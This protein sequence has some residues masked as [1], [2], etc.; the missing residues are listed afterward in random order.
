MGLYTIKECRGLWLVLN[1]HGTVVYC[2]TYQE[3]ESY[4]DQKDNVSC[5]RQQDSL[6]AAATIATRT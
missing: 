6:T 2:G 4:L 5:T 3:V 1:D